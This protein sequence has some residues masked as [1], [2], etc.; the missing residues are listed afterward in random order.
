M[1]RRLAFYFFIFSYFSSTIIFAQT[2]HATVDAT[3]ISLGETITYKIEA[4][5]ASE[6]PEVDI[7]PAL[8]QFDLLSGPGQQTNIQW[9][10]GKMSSNY[11]LT[12]TLSPK[13]TG[14]L[15]IPKLWV[16]LGDKTYQTTSVKIR[17]GKGNVENGSAIFIRAELDKESIFVGE[18]LTVTYKLYRNVNFSPSPYNLPDFV[19]FWSEVVY[20]PRSLKF[21]NV[22][23]NGKSYQV[24]DL[25]KVALFP[26]KTGKQNIPPI[27]IQGQMEKKSK[28]NRG[29]NSAFDPFF[30]SFFTETITKQIRSPEKSIFVKTYPKEKPFDFSGAVGSFKISTELDTDSAKVNEGFTFIVR[31]KGT[32][33]LGQF[34]LSEIQFPET[35]EAFP[36]KEN[37]KKDAFRDELTGVS[38]WEYILIPRQAGKLLLPRIK[39][40]Y[41]NPKNQRWEKTQS[42]V[43]EISILPGE[44]EK[45]NSG[46][47][48]KRE[49]ELLGKD[50]RFIHTESTEFS[51]IQKSFI[52]RS[53][54]WI[55]L[56]AGFFAFMPIW[57][58]KATDYRLSTA[59]G[60]LSRGAL[61]KSKKSLK[62]KTD[63]PFTLASQTIYVYFFERLDLS[64]PN[65]DPA[66]VKNE[67]SGRIPN[68][69]S[70][71]LMTLLQ[72]CDSGRFAPGGE[73][74]V[75]TILFDTKNL[76]IQ[77]ESKLK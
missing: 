4:V 21:R 30:N 32:G 17:V 55:Y 62:Q 56:L 49:V 77:L 46:K 31:L 14:T 37:F 16:K 15:T 60:R 48:T 23:L 3:Q 58:N 2:L 34:S 27:H 73:A 74:L 52:S 50:I 26:M 66:L 11:S 29:R 43:Q 72:Q 42:Q 25:L 76:L 6:M 54:I 8:K 39:M 28:R 64:S 18:Q 57:I 36:P 59:T 22:R 71:R 24:A 19:G 51:P 63:D 67:L 7:L 40:S 75:D 13:K 41:F 70:Q 20:T 44:I 33:N 12:W 9:I 47:Y 35:V 69:L 1:F 68:E 38:T 10:N 45:Y 61:K 53:V 5:G 65:L